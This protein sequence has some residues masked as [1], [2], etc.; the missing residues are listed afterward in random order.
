MDTP[1]GPPRVRESGSPELLESPSTSQNFLEL[2]R[3]LIGEFP[4]TSLTVDFKSNPGGSFEV[5]QTSPQVPRFPR[6]R[7]T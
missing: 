1:F 4:G 7:V 2:P 5:A 6:I 3:K